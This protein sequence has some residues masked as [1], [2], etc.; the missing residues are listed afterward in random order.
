M[1]SLAGS[2]NKN[3]IV[4]LD[5]TLKI[6]RFYGDG[7]RRDLARELKSPAGVIFDEGRSPNN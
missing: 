4:K 5:L 6:N 3:T 2:T 1:Q 7:S